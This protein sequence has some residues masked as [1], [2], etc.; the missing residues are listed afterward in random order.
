[1]HESPV[2]VAPKERSHECPNLSPVLLTDLAITV[3]VS[4]GIVLYVRRHLKT[5]EFGLDKSMVFEM[6]TLFKQAL[7]GF[8][9]TPSGIPRDKGIISAPSR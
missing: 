1:M 7:I 5:L 6:V 9:V 3:P 2:R 8:V 4:L